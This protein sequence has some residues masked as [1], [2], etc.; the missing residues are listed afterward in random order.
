M[1]SKEYKE[2]KGLR[3]ENLRD[4]MDS[5]ELIYKSIDLCIAIDGSNT[6]SILSLPNLA[7]H[8]FIGSAFLENEIYSK[9]KTIN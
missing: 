8:C 3:K 4:N 7:N 1:T 2:Y 9:Q 6:S 5:I